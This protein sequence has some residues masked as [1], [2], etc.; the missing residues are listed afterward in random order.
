M[1]KKILAEIDKRIKDR[2]NAIKLTHGYGIAYNAYASGLNELQ[3]IRKI[4]SKLK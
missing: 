4:I 1:K 2:K 3:A